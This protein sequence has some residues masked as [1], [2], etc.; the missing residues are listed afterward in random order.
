MS[1]TICHVT[2]AYINE[3]VYA[4][5]MTILRNADRATRGM[6]GGMNYLARCLRILTAC[7]LCLQYSSIA[8]CIF[9]G[10]VCGTILCDRGCDTVRERRGGVG[11]PKEAMDI[12]VAG[13]NPMRRA[14]W[15][16]CG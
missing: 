8:R 1:G 12:F 11:K 2:V 15:A 7:P 16:N 13:R 6:T 5:T 4:V 10:V 3:D 9:G 14:R